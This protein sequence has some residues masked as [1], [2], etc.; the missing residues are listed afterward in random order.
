M[1][2]RRILGISGAVFLGV[3]ALIVA[4]GIRYSV[5]NDGPPGSDTVA[6]TFYT[7]NHRFVRKPWFEFSVFPGSTVSPSFSFT[8]IPRWVERGVLAF[9][10]EPRFCNAEHG[11]NL[12]IFTI[13]EAPHRFFAVGF[14]LWRTTHPT[15]SGANYTE[16]SCAFGRDPIREYRYHPE[17]FQGFDA[18]IARKRLEYAAHAEL[19]DLPAA[20]YPA[21]DK[22]M[23]PVLITNP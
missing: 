1:I 16:I 21:H 11:Q 10:R 8:V 5:L 6:F 12:H 14:F 15:D 9:D 3:G 17:A 19:R 7:Q 23:Y 20:T 2:I 22:T 18:I 13:D 4:A